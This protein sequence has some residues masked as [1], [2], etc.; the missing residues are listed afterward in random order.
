MTVIDR[1][2]LWRQFGAA[3]DMLGN[4]LRDCPAELWE[5]SLWP[6][7]RVQGAANGFSAFWY[8]GFHTLFW[9]D[10]YLTG[11]VEGFAPPPP[12]DLVELDPAGVLPPHYTRAEL[13]DYLAYC[14]RKCQDTLG[15]LT[16]AP[17]ARLCSFPWG[18]MPY[19]ELQLYNLRHVQ[20]HGAQLRMFLGQQA[21]LPAKW[22][23]RAKDPG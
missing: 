10:L 2:M 1:E 3:I 14:R 11:T 16:S 15:A 13:L 4:A 12:Y 18:Q 6:D 17:A 23:G 9:L 22:V 7:P 20:E 21:A 19:A 8:L 5:K